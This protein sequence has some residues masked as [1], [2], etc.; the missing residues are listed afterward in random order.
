MPVDPPR[1]IPDVNPDVIQSAISI[2]ISNESEI[3]NMS[4]IKDAMHYFKELCQVRQFE[5]VSETSRVA[6]Y[7]NL[8]NGNEVQ[9]EKRLGQRLIAMADLESLLAAFRIMAN[10]DSAILVGD[11]RV[12]VVY[13]F[14]NYEL[15]EHEV[16][17]TIYGN[18]ETETHVNLSCSPIFHFCKTGVSGDP[19]VVIRWLNYNLASAI[20]APIDIAMKLSSLHF[21]TL[22][23]ESHTV[24]PKDE[25]VSRSIRNKATGLDA[26]PNYFTVQFPMYPGIEDQLS[27]MVDLQEDPLTTTVAIRMDLH[28]DPSAQNK[29]SVRPLPGEIEQATIRAT[30][31]IQT[32]L[33]LSVGSNFE[34]RVFLA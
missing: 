9:I 23:Q 19:K 1:L 8:H 14:F 34:N 33:K 5:K 3:L 7:V 26:I 25:G 15:D 16:G 24:Q 10:D 29:V 2:I 6:K 20:L 22:S 30:Q 18:H 28:I 11:E 21:E 17:K 12:S 32:F 4:L 13:D 27:N 31:A